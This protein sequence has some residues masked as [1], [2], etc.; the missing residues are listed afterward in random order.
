MCAA[1]NSRV[2]DQGPRPA[3]LPPAVGCLAWSGSVW[4]T[5]DFVED[6]HDT[7]SLDE[8]SVGCKTM[9]HTLKTPDDTEAR[10]TVFFMACQTTKQEKLT[11]TQTTAVLPAEQEVMWS[12]DLDSSIFFNAFHH[13]NPCVCTK[14][15]QKANGT[16]LNGSF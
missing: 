12:T 16:N 7:S 15:S 3:A 9:E 14:G 6:P 13:N 1:P 2:G 5:L 11:C 4:Y 10:P 8:V